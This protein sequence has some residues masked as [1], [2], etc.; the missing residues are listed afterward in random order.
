MIELP[1]RFSE[2]TIAALR[3]SGRRFVDVG[4]T[5]TINKIT[6]RWTGAEWID[7]TSVVELP[8]DAKGPKLG[9]YGTDKYGCKTIFDGRV[10][11]SIRDPD[12]TKGEDHF[13]VE[14]ND[15]CQL[16]NIAGD[17]VLGNGNMDTA[18]LFGRILERVEGRL[19]AV[20]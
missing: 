11:L 19:N 16:L 2:Y 4:Q 10:W 13:A 1:A 8:G 6:K 5:H 15:L 12:E 7:A 14:D 17:L 9:D 18:I 20:N 3:E